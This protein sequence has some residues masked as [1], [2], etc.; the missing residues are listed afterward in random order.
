MNCRIITAVRLNQHLRLRGDIETV[1][2]LQSQLCNSGLI[3]YRERIAPA[4]SQTVSPAAFEAIA[5][6]MR[7]SA[8]ANCSCSL[9]AVKPPPAIVSICSPAA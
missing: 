6:N 9:S 8:A 5:P 4:H 1:R 7:S 2:T 3:G